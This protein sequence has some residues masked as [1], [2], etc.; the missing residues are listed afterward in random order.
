MLRDR[1]DPMNLFEY[2]PTLSM[3]RDPM[4]TQ[5]DTLLDDDGLFQAVL[6]CAGGNRT[7]TLS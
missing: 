5:M 1:Y 3:Q 7:V 6:M 4:L 2:I